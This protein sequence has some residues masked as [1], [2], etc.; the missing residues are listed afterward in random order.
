MIKKAVIPTAGFGTRFLPITKVLSKSI[1]PIV[2]QPS[3]AWIVNEAVASGITDLYI[4]VNPNEHQVSDYF[5]ENP[6]FEKVLLDKNKQEAYRMLKKADV[7]VHFHFIVQKQPLG[8]GHAVLMAEPYI[9]DESF[10]I[11]LADDLYKHEIPALKQLITVYQKLNSNLIGTIKVSTED[12]PFY[13]ICIPKIKQNS[14]YLELANV[15]EKPAASS[16]ESRQAIGGRYIL[17]SSIFEILKSQPKGYGDEIQ[18]TDAI[19]VLMETEK[20]YAQ[21]LVGKRYDL[22]KKIDY[23][24]AIIDFGLEHEEIGTLVSKL[25]LDKAKNI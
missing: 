14:A 2:D 5:K 12:V 10:A 6:T 3:I 20:V 22:G 13:G 11:M 21:P 25:I 17:S 4:I 9:K 1:L 7:D 23:V 18:L 16:T 19:R 15:I 24:E 8:L